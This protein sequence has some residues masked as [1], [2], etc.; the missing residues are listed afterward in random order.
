MAKTRTISAERLVVGDRLLR[1]NGPKADVLEIMEISRMF[2]GDLS[3]L[4]GAKRLSKF[5][6]R[7]EQ[8]TIEVKR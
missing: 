7:D 4:L 6:Y 5:L 8:V 1:F 2:G 3:V